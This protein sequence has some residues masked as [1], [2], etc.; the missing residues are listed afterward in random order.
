MAQQIEVPGMG[1]VEFPDGMSDD[2][3]AAAIRQSMPPTQKPIDPSEGRLPLRPF[4]IDTGLTMPQ[5]VSRFMAGAGKAFADIGRG[6][7]TMVTDA[8]PSAA[9][10]GLATRKDVDESKMRDAPLMNTGAGIA[11]NIVGNMAAYA[12][13]AMVPGAATVGGGALIGGG[14]GFMQPVGTEDSRFQNTAVGTAAGAVVPAAIRTGKALR[15]GLV[16]P[17]T[18]AGRNKIAGALINR[19]AA[20]PAA[21]SQRLQTAQGN[22]PGFMPTVGQAADDAGVASLERTMRAIDPRGFD[23]VD[24]SQR[25][26]LVDAL[27]SVAKTPEAKSA[28]IRA[29]EDAVK[30]L[31]GAAKKAVVAGDDQLDALLQRPSMMTAQERAAKIAAE[32]GEKFELS[33]A[34]PEQTVFVGGQSLKVP[35]GHHGTKTVQQPG[36]LDASGNP[37]TRTI[38]ATEAQYPGQAL[39]DIKMGLDDAIGSPGTGGMQGAERDAAIATKEQFLNWLEGKIPEYGQAKQTYAKMSRPI[40]QIDIGQELYNR[41]TPALADQGGLPFKSTAQAYANALRNGDD[42]ARNVTG[43]KSATLRGVMEPEQMQ[44]LEAV[45]KD[46]AVKAAAENVGRGAGSDTVQKIAM[47]NLAAEAGVPN[48]LASIA[49]VPGGWAKR[50]GDV[51]YGG[52]DDQVRARLA[53]IMANPQEA[54]AAMQAAGATP[55]QIAE[56]LKLGAQGVGLSAFPALN[57]K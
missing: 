46:S 15:A 17:F 8:I 22:T 35:G 36:L 13:L 29:R 34:A 52:S 37:I 47:T 25:G 40:N 30:P 16:D 49:R 24:K 9:N 14:T 20:D 45:A 41:F 56:A 23:A 10:I 28:A 27:R 48:W 42:L 18:E 6:A 31:Y 57:G 12:P 26:A 54:A 53:E 7:G 19:A 55:S 21:V 39:H 5:G 4:G 11:G 51:L 1:I 43:M 2:A 32:R 44:I 33:Q 3:I 38:P 50:A